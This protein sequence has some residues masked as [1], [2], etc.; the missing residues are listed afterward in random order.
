MSYLYTM[1]ISTELSHCH[2]IQV[3]QLNSQIEARE[4]EREEM[5][6]TGV[7]FLPANEE[8]VKDF[9]DKKIHFS[10]RL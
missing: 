5:V 9:Q 3:F 2:L 6:F 8:N 10:N 1:I 7:P 4:R